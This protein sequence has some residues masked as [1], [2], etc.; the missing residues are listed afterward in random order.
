MNSKKT[1]QIALYIVLTAF[2]VIC[3]GTVLIPAV[4][5]VIYTWQW[6]LIYPVLLVLFMIFAPKK[7]R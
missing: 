2:A 1:E 4:L 6:L 5:A 3:I 7:L